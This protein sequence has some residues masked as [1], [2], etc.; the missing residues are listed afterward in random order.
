MCNLFVNFDLICSI[1]NL[2]GGIFLN[3]IGSIF[4]LIGNIFAH[5]YEFELLSLHKERGGF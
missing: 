1:C 5:K 3:L 2:I 4:N